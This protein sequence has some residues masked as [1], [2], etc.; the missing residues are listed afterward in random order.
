MLIDCRWTYLLAKD[1][2][3][4]FQLLPDVI[5]HS[6]LPRYVVEEQNLLALNGVYLLDSISADVMRM[7][8]YF[9]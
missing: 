4:V 7:I 6:I 8:H 2:L 3:N 1:H 5:I 9:I